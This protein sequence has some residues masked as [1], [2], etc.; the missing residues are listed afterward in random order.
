MLDWHSCQ[1]CYSL[2]IKL[3][4]LLCKNKSILRNFK[5]ATFYVDCSLYWVDL[6]LFLIQYLILSCDK[7]QFTVKRILLR[8]FI[9]SYH[10]VSHF[11]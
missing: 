10:D 6:M 3:L 2:E 7:Q 5:N 1:I 11:Q 9:L 8:P 4:L